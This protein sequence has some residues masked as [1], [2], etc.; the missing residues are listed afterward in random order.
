MTASRASSGWGCCSYNNHVAPAR[1]TLGERRSLLVL[2]W[3]P[4][5]YRGPHCRAAH[6]R[7]PARAQAHLRTAA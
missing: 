2:G 3:P 7:P 1:P 4:R 5:L 6:V